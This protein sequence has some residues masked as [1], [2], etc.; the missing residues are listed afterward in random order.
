MS[1]LPKLGTA[2]LALDA[3]AALTSS[4]DAQSAGSTSIEGAAGVGFRGPGE[5]AA[6]C[7]PFRSTLERAQ[8]YWVGVGVGRWV[9]PRVGLEGE[10]TWAAESPYTAYVQG[11]FGDAPYR[12][13][14]ADNRITTFTL[15]ALLRGRA[16]KFGQGSL[17]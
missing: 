1:I 14:R 4:A 8:S 7:G 6:C 10:A 9:G 13:Y 2:W 3:V 5:T 15:A 12:G 16:A 17:D 11:T